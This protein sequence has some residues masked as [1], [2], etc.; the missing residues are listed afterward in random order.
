[1]TA[2][3]AEHKAKLNRFFGRLAYQ[4][5][6]GDLIED[7]LAM[8]STEITLA[9]GKILIGDATGAS[10]AKTPSGDMT[11]TREGVVSLAADCVDSAEIA[12]DAVD[13]EHIAA[14]AVD[15]EHLSSALVDLAP[16]Q[17]L[18]DFTT[19]PVVFGGA[20]LLG[21]QAVT[22][23]AVNGA[24][25]KNSWFWR[26][27]INQQDIG[28]SWVKGSGIEIAGDQTENDGVEFNMGDTAS[29]CQKVVDTDNFYF[30]AKVKVADVSGTDDFYIGLR[31]AQAHQD[32]VD[33]YTDY[34]AVGAIDKAGSVQVLSDLNNAGETAT[35]TTDDLG[36]GE[37]LDVKIWQGDE[38]RL[39]TAIDLATDLKSVINT[40][41]ADAGE[42]G[43]EH[44][45]AQ[46]A[47]AVA[48]PTTVATLIAS[49]SEMQDAYAA[50]EADAQLGADWVYHQAD[51]GDD[52]SLASDTNPTTLAEC[53]TV[54][55]DI[56]T[57]FALHIADATAHT[58]GDN[59]GATAVN[60]C[61]TYCQI[62]VNGALA[63]PTAT[64]TFDFDTGDTLVP[65]IYMLQS[66]D[67]TGDVHV[68]N[69]EVVDVTT[70]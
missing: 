62:G 49:V 1:M 9:D 44:I 15:E 12:D 58:A 61:N 57:K 17:C 23:N 27:N 28:M 3:S 32:A 26:H 50:H 42:A 45:A 51:N 40:H 38:A 39:Q 35:D 46:T 31:K 4:I 22:D 21:V 8:A 53:V 67:F 20:G 63:D 10:A 56:K 30:R 33:S 55:N 59:S 47:L 65:F 54:L 13:S 29:P 24:W 60:A 64:H 48:T 18:C 43:E 11:M 5:Q 37:Y 7:A 6:L 69:W 66:D 25:C 16:G 34:F 2:L 19:E 41:F 68:M 14:G 36:N 52:D 70:T